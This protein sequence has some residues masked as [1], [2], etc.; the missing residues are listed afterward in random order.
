MQKYILGQLSQ[1]SFWIG[2]V[3]VLIAFTAPR[4]YIVILGIALMLTD[5]AALKGWLAKRSPW[6]AAKIQEW[7]NDV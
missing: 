7:M 3:L 4:V 6:L 5:D 2:V 1:V